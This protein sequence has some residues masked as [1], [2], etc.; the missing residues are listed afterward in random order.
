MAKADHSLDFLGLHCPT[1]LNQEQKA[2]QQACIPELHCHVSE[3]WQINKLISKIALPRKQR[4]KP[5]S[6]NCTA[7]VFRVKTGLRTGKSMQE[8]CTAWRAAHLEGF[9]NMHCQAPKRLTDQ[10]A[11]FEKWSARPFSDGSAA[12]RFPPTALPGDKC[13]AVHLA[14]YPDLVCPARKF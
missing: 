7:Q 4:S 9:P 13:Q 11:D 3:A 2:A 8:K 5:I 10:K 12:R 1:W 6:P 14:L